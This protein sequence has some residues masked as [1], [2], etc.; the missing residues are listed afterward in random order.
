MFQFL[1]TAIMIIIM[2]RL[3]FVFPSH[4][5]MFVKSEIT[6]RQMLKKNYLT[7]NWNKA[8]QNL[9]FQNLD[10]NVSLLNR[11]LLNI[12]R[13]YIPNKKLSETIDSLHGWLINQKISWKKDLNWQNIFTE[14]VKWRVILIKCWENL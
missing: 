3:T 13:N 4:Q 12:F 5:Y 10:E 8:F 2:V 6:R 7:L 9:A 1:I 11:I 14:L